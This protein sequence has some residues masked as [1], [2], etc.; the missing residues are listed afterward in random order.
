MF[1]DKY[2]SIAEKWVVKQDF[3]GLLFPS[4]ALVALRSCLPTWQ[5]V[6]RCGHISG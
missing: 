6:E 1:Y 3:P 4:A 2:S 5:C